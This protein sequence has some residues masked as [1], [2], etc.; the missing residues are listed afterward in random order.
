MTTEHA[1]ELWCWYFVAAFRRGQTDARKQRAFAHMDALEAKY[2]A[3]VPSEH[4]LFV[5]RVGIAERMAQKREASA[6]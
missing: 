2:P 1:R 5:A 4:D 3:I 6:V